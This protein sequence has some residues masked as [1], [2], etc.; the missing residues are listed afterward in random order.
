[1]H[2][3]WTSFSLFRVDM[4]I[5]RRRFGST[6]VAIS[7]DK[8]RFILFLLLLLL[9]LLILAFLLSA[10]A[11]LWRVTPSIS[12]PPTPT[13]T[14]MTTRT[15]TETAAV[16]DG[17][18]DR[19]GGCGKLLILTW[20]VWFGR[21][22]QAE[23]YSAIVRELL[24]RDVDVACFQEVTAPFVDALLS[25]EDVVERYDVSPDRVWYVGYGCLTLA[26]KGL[27]A[28]FQ[29]VAI[30]TWMGRSLLVTRLRVGVGGV[31]VAD[32]EKEPEEELSLKNM[33]EVHLTKK[34]MRKGGGD[35]CGGGGS[36]I[37]TVGNVHLESLDNER[38]RRGQL[39]VANSVLGND[40]RVD[41][42][43][44]VSEVRAVLCGDFN[45]DSSMTWGDWKLG[46][47]RGN[48]K[49][50]QGKRPPR[51]PEEL[52]NRVLAEEMPDWVDAW[53]AIHGDVGSGGDPG[54]TFDGRTNPACVHDRDE[55]MRYDRIMVKGGEVADD[56]ASSKAE[57]S[58][59]TGRKAEN[60][61][62]GDGAKN[63]SVSSSPLLLENIVMIGTEP[64]DETGVKPSDHYGLVISLRV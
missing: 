7:T 38:T 11:T 1:V 18:H 37:V 22:R 16:A 23:R 57:E 13:I 34:E 48:S 46:R 52:E 6:T 61:W 31:G 5:R 58:K 55:R 2:E 20:N 54:I 56:V 64:L 53:P 44:R 12:T 60:V 8:F 47:G 26:K 19:D 43:G 25:S 33:N 27:G 59:A 4:T 30:P 9:P 3:V 42:S 49:S 28:D 39:R 21:Y 50:K 36:V 51:P 35:G 41:A 45:F 15:T 40:G 10:R 24:R 14:M 17:R 62:E 63:R 29:N 32:E